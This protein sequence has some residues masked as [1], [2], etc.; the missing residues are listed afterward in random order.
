VADKAGENS[1]AM[2]RDKTPKSN[3]QIT[4]SPFDILYLSV[5]ICSAGKRWD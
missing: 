4:K 1:S 3:I 2:Y 5:G